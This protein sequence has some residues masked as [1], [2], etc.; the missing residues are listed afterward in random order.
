MNFLSYFFS[1]NFIFFSFPKARL[2]EVGEG[3]TKVTT[4]PWCGELGD[5]HSG[6]EERPQPK[7]NQDVE[8]K[9]IAPSMCL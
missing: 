6:F 2:W 5:S 9:E 8:D 7:T 1:M 4:K 3:V